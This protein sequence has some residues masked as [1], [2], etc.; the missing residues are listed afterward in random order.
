MSII[1]SLHILALVGGIMDSR[2]GLIRWRLCG[3][4]LAG[5]DEIAREKYPYVKRTNKT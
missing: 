2:D 3:W 1:S 5:I 4:K